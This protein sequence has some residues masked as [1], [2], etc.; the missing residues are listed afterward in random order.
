MKER[1][2]K[3]IARCGVCSRRNADVLIAKGLVNLNGKRVT[4]MGITIDPAID[5]VI[6]KNKPVLPEKNFLYILMNKP[7]G[8]VTTLKD[9]E[10][11]PTVIDLLC[12][13]KTRLFPVGRLDMD[14]KG[15]LLL[16]ND[17]D[18]ANRLAHPRYGIKKTYRVLIHKRINESDLKKLEKGIELEDG[19]TAPASVHLDKRFEHQ[20]L[21]TIKIAEGKKRQIRRMFEAIDHEVLDLVRI[22][23]GPL[24]LGR[25]KPGEYREILPEEVRTLEKA[26]LLFR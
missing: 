13:I 2:N 4:E 3:F 1:L 23:Y 18:L 21:V 25:L 24:K 12:G 20:S 19:L 9:E 16:T 14:T 15:L 22:E 6:V 10:K 8:Y 17:G 26:V 5:R 11:R 7:A